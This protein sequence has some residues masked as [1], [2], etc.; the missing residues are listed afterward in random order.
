MNYDR[1]V[2]LLQALRDADVSAMGEAMISAEEE[3]VGAL[4]T[5]DRGRRRG[6]LL[7]AAQGLAEGRLNVLSTV[8]AA[9]RYS[10]VRGD[11]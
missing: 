2:Y 5:V 7:N 4:E 6:L 9:Q 11:Y 1:A 8:T 3:L 10:R